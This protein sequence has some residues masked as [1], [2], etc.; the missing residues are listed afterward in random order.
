[1]TDTTA[2]IYGQPVTIPAH[3]LQ[4]VDQECIRVN[5]D[6]AAAD[7][8]NAALTAAFP[9]GPPGGCG[10]YIDM[11]STATLYKAG[12]RVALTVRLVNESGDVVGQ[13]GDTAWVEY[14]ASDLSAG[15]LSRGDRHGPFYAVHFEHIPYAN[16]NYVAQCELTWAGDPWAQEGTT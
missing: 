11:T 6:Q 1:M 16:L 15:V 13:P 8:F 12:D 14:I 9:D 2:A 10:G 4:Y 5:G 3:L 7:A